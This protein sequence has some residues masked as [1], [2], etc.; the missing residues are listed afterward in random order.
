MVTG[1]L[2]PLTHVSNWSRNLQ[3]SLIVNLK[4]GL[5]YTR[6]TSLLVGQEMTGYRLKTTDD[7]VDKRND[8]PTQRTVGLTL[9]TRKQGDKSE[10]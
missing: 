8:Q 2:E 7:H 6:C 1:P 3:T 9:T 4:F 5:P 10:A